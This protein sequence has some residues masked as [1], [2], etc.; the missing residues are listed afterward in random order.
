VF[1][2]AAGVVL[3]QSDLLR[4]AVDAHV[5]QRHALRKREVELE[6][7]RLRQRVGRA[8]RVADDVPT[9]YINSVHVSNVTCSQCVIHTGS[10]RS[11][12]TS[13]LTDKSSH[14]LVVRSADDRLRP[15]SN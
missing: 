14:T 10:S 2:P 8:R 13:H 1:V 4:L 7:G 15:S 6:A 5:E 9:S 11:R 12:S 3:L